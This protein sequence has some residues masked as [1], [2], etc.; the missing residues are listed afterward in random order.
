MSTFRCVAEGDAADRVGQRNSHPKTD[1]SNAEA[2][3]G[4]GTQSN[5]HLIMEG[6]LTAVAG[7]VCVGASSPRLC[8]AT[9]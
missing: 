7:V 5:Q 1:L 8:R 9:E 3:L 2:F 4:L 6:E